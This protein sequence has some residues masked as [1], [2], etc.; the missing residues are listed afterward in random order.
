MRCSDCSKKVRPVVAIDM[1]GTLG[2]YHGHF[3]RFAAEWTGLGTE[4]VLQCSLH[5][6]DGSYSFGDYV[7]RMF[8]IDRTT[9]RSIKLAYR[10]GGLKRSMPPLPGHKAICEMVR[11]EGAELWITTTRPYLSLDN[12]IPDTVA[13]FDREQIAFD[14]MLFDADKYAVLAERVDRERVVAVVDDLGEMYD[15]AARYFGAGIPILAIGKFN[16]GVRREHSVI[17]PDAISFVRHNIRI[18]RIENGE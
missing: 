6:Y 12:I 9:Y 3:L 10:Q 11:Q 5:M 18:W 7:C 1:D 17:L 14:H 13:W 4:I 2:D 16:Y 8:G 15:A